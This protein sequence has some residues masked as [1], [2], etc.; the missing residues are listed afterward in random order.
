MINFKNIIRHILVGSTRFIDIRGFEILNEMERLQKT[1]KYSNPL[2]LIPFGK[3][4]YSQN[5]ED[6][7][8]IEIFKRIGTN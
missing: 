5:D 6:G 2:N 4:I 1:A 3:K 7:I 8:I